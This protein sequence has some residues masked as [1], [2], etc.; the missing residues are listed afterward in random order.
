MSHILR[1]NELYTPGERKQLLVDLWNLDHKQFSMTYDVPLHSVRFESNGIRRVFMVYREGKRHLKTLFKNEYGFD[2]GV[3]DPLKSEEQYGSIELFGDLF[4][5]NLDC[6]T[7]KIL[8]IYKTPG[9]K[10]LITSV[11]DLSSGSIIPGK[12]AI[13]LP[14]D[15]FHSILFGLCWFIQIPVETSEKIMGRTFFHSDHSGRRL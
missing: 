4:Y 3:I 6:L 8:N 1:N 7:E 9:A 10:P 12:A 5:Y 13:Q 2:I 15:F 14:E 11:L